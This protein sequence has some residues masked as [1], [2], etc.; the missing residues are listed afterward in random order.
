MTLN[1]CLP[2]G[3]NFINNDEIEQTMDPSVIVTRTP[4]TVLVKEWG[5]TAS[6]GRLKNAV[7]GVC[8]ESWGAGG[9]Y[10]NLCLK[11]LNTSQC[12][13]L[14]LI[15]IPRRKVNR[16]GGEGTSYCL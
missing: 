7:K 12:I 4:H 1:P 14:L 11:T 9:N 8:K 5:K 15:R 16:R 3:S 2:T 10:N 6:W 13:F